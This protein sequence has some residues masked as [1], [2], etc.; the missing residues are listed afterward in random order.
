MKQTSKTAKR[1]KKPVLS[2]LN[3]LEADI[4]DIVWDHKKI[5]VRDVHEVMMEEGYIPYTTVMAAMNNMSLKGLLK[6]NRNGRA[7]VYS[8]AVSREQMACTIMDAVIDRV[9]EGDRSVVVNYLSEFVEQKAT[10]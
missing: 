8:A 10:K 6:Q 3:E 9:L 5:T 1:S 4:M 2:G 7:F